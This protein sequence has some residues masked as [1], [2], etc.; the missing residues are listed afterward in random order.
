MPMSS[1]IDHDRKIVFTRVWGDLT[2]EDVKAYQSELSHNSQFS[3]EFS[4]LMDMTDLKTVRLSSL[5]I[6]RLLK[7]RAFAK[8]VRWGVIAESDLAFGISRMIEVHCHE[9]K[10]PFRS[11][12]KREEAEA[13]FFASPEDTDAG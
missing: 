12:R 3:P 6:D 8:G 2:E 1:T 5:S 10:I 9:Q 13:W 7:T 4:Q 11:F